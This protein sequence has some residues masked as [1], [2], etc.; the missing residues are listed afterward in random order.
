MT[1]IAITPQ[2][3]A[4][5]WWLWKQCRKDTSEIAAE[6]KVRESFVARRLA[7]MLDMDHAKPELAPA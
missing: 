2:H 4:D 6:L 3:D 5:I 7:Y 1:V